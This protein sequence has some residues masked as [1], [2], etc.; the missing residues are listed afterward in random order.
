MLV[1]GNVV[2]ALLRGWRLTQLTKSKAVEFLLV[3]SLAH[4][5]AACYQ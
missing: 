3:I 1:A 2:G 4:Y 5:T